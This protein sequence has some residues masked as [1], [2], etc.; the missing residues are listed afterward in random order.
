MKNHVIGLDIIVVEEHYVADSSWSS[1]M[2]V[3]KVVLQDSMLGPL[4]FIFFCYFLLCVNVRICSIHYAIHL[5]ADDAILYTTVP[6]AAQVVQKL[7]F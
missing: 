4:L 3:N 7:P 1:F 2:S 5:Y 6:S